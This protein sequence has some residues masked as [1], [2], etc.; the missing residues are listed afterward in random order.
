MCLS[1]CR[2][3]R[4]GLRSASDT[5]RLMEPNSVKLLKSASIRTFYHFAPQT[6][7]ALTVSIRESDSLSK[8]KKCVK[9]YLYPI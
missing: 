5:T 1:P 2:P 3:A 7:N 4:S 6:W 8:F 9:N